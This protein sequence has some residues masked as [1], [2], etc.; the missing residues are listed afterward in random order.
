MEGVSVVLATESVEEGRERLVEDTAEA[1]PQVIEVPS[2]DPGGGE[3][4]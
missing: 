4:S 3:K 2:D 1:H